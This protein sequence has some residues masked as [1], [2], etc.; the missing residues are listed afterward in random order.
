MEE[1]RIARRLGGPPLHH[2]CADA[3]SNDVSIFELK[4]SEHAGSFV[5]VGSGLSEEEIADI[6]AQARNMEG[7]GGVADYE[8]VIA[9]QGLGRAVRSIY[10]ITVAELRDAIPITPMTRAPHAEPWQL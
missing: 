7:G 9:F 3:L 10:P 1:L 4:D 5:L 8:S 2:K 6:H